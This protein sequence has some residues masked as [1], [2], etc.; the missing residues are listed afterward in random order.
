MTKNR[1]INFLLNLYLF[2]ITYL[3]I[4]LY[5]PVFYANKELAKKL[6]PSPSTKTQLI[7][8]LIILVLAIGLSVF[9]KRAATMSRVVL[10]SIVLLAAVYFSLYNIK[11]NESTR[12]PLIFVVEPGS[13]EDL[14]ETRWRREI[15]FDVY[16]TAY[17]KYPLHNIRY[18]PDIPV[19]N[20][21]E[22]E[23]I[24]R[25]GVYLSEDETLSPSISSTQFTSLTANSSLA[26]T[27][28]IDGETEYLFFDPID[29][30]LE[31]VLTTYDSKV[32]FAPRSYFDE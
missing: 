29:R 21:L 14:A 27:S 9:A 17:Q 12:I 19:S 2:S 32:I 31:L 26:S 15:A 22:L 8:Y 30:S 18:H 13:I 20:I 11:D 1:I 5:I 16:F 7:G 3:V 4:V 25:F 28:V 23:R 24:N 6:P 10:I